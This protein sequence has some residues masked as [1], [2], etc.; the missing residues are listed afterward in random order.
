MSRVG[1]QPIKILQGVKAEIKDGHAHR[2]R[3]TAAVEWLKAGMPL[4]EVS[5]LLDHKSI[6]TTEK[7]YA[8][9]VQARQRR[10]DALLR[11]ATAKIL[12][13]AKNETQSQEAGLQANQP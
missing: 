12:E 2:L 9:W 5:R 6:K 10:L 8:P 3:D 7:Y 4:E 1:K 13:A 11:D